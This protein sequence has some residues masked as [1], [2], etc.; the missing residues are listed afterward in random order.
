MNGAEAARETSKRWGGYGTASDMRVRRA[1]GPRCGR[2]P[3]RGGPPRR[4]SPR[5]PRG[6]RA[7]RPIPGDQARVRG[8]GCGDRGGGAGAA[9]AGRAHADEGSADAGDAGGDAGEDDS[10][11]AAQDIVTVD[12]E[13]NVH[14][15]N[16]FEDIIEQT[17]YGPVASFTLPVG[18][19]VCADCE[20]RAVTVQANAAAGPSRW[21]AASTTPRGST[22]RCWQAPWAA[23]P[24]RRA[25]PAAPSACSPGSRSTTPPTPGRSTRRRSTARPWT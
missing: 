8:G 21:S 18:C 7:G 1:C 13:G 20:T 10:G 6:G 3:V 2:D 14:I 22:R 11:D 17:V 16:T 19:T 9:A 5:A 4:P 15:I 25:R 23:P 24:S 12:D